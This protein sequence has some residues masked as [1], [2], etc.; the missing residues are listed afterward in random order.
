[1]CPSSLFKVSWMVDACGAEKNRANHVKII[2]NI[3]ELVCFISK[4][5]T[6]AKE[7]NHFELAKF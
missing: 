1:M 7:Q 2:S 6:R 3:N 5:D 4:N